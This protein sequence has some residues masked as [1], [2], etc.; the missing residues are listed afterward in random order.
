MTCSLFYLS[1]L[2]K[3]LKYIFF[4]VDTYK[5]TRIQHVVNTE[6][7]CA[8]VRVCVCVCLWHEDTNLYNDMGMT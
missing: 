6:A 7:V 8:C 4:S 5:R 1:K 2:S 3:Q